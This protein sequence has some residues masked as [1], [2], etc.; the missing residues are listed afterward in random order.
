VL[1]PRPGEGDA[2]STGLARV[3]VFLL[4]RE[5]TQSHPSL[6]QSRGGPRVVVVS[7]V[8]SPKW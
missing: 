1:L 4:L 5:E 2:W 3:L 8:D 7:T 6:I